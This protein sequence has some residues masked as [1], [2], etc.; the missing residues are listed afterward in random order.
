[1]LWISRTGFGYDFCFVKQPRYQLT[2]A[3]GQAVV[4]IAKRLIHDEG[5]TSKGLTRRCLMRASWGSDA[6]RGLVIEKIPPKHF[7]V[8]EVNDWAFQVFRIVLNR[9]HWV[10]QP[11]Y[12]RMFLDPIEPVTP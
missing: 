3:A 8:T 5:E 4:A 2:T 9:D 10:V 7:H 12:R 1:M 11:D 6:E